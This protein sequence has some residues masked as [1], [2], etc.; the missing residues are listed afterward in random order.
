MKSQLRLNRLAGHLAATPTSVTAWYRIPPLGWSFR[1]NGQRRSLINGMADAYAQLARRSLHLRVTTRPYPVRAWAQRHHENAPD[2]LPSFPDYLSRQVRHLSKFS[3]AEKE[4]YIG[5]SIPLPY[6]TLRPY[7]GAFMPGVTPALLRQLAPKVRETDQVMAASTFRA[8][9]ARLEELEWLLHRSVSL[10]MPAP[11]TTPTRIDEDWEPEDFAEFTDQ[12]DWTAVPFAPTINVRGSIDG[13]EVE[14]HVR[15]LS[16]GR[17]TGQLVA[18]GDPWMQRSD[19]MPFPVEWSARVSVQEAEVVTGQMRR[20]MQKIRAQIRHYKDEHDEEPPTSLSDAHHDAVRVEG[21]LQ[22]GLSGASMRARGWWRVAVSGA[23]EEE[24]VERGRALAKEMRPQVPLVPVLDQYKTARE[25]IPGEP[26]ANNNYVRRMRVDTLA[27]AAPAATARIGDRVGV[28]LGVTAGTTA[29][30]TM[31]EPWLFSTEPGKTSGCTVIVAGLGG[32]KTTLAG[33]I[34]ENTAQGG[35]P[36]SV[37]DP[38][39]RLG[40]LCRLPDLRD[41]SEVVSVMDSEPGI[42]SPFRVVADPNPE[43]F[44]DD[45]DGRKEYQRAVEYARETRRTLINT[46][47]LSL[48][49]AST[50]GNEN[51]EPAMWNALSRVS[52]SRHGKM[53]DVVQSLRHLGGENET[54]RRHASSIA[55]VLAGVAQT[56]HGRLLFGNPGVDDVRDFNEVLLRVYSLKG[57]SLPTDVQTGQELDPD[58]R[59]SFVIYYLAAW[60]TQRQMYFGDPNQRKGIFIDEGWVLEMFAQGRRFIESCDRDSRKHN[61][62]VL[63]AD[64]NPG[65]PLRL[66]MDKYASAVFIGRLD[67]EAAQ[68]EAIKLISKLPEDQGY[69]EVLGELGAEDDDDARKWDDEAANELS[70]EGDDSTP[71]QFVM[72]VGGNDVERI[73]VDLTAHPQLAAALKTSADRTKVRR[74]VSSNLPVL[75]ESKTHSSPAVAVDVEV[76]PAI[77]FLEDQGQGDD[78]GDDQD[79]DQD[80]DLTA[81]QDTAAPT[82]R[83]TPTRPRPTRSTTKTSSAA[84]S[85]TPAAPARKKPTRATTKAETSGTAS[86]RT[87]RKAA[88]ASRRSAQSATTEAAAAS[89]SDADADAESASSAPDES[90]LEATATGTAAATETSGQD[91]QSTTAE[92][93][94]GMPRRRV[95]AA[96]SA[97][98]TVTSAVPTSTHQDSD[99]TMNPPGDPA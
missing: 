9:P 24:A 83:K 29:R 70:G 26:L 74:R 91:P 27:A 98:H 75:D 58:E 66:G 44:H 99:H 76:H 15:I 96:R 14:R 42:L 85:P 92:V 37:L 79:D 28:P 18:P 81:T 52:L 21:E 57:L 39:G 36:W 34:I 20:A 6:E 30:W 62:R 11:L 82:R 1:P 48:L 77:P 19:W 78:Q 84:A 65:G 69:E 68:G 97:R 95:A 41:H 43:H 7:V 93:A 67:S 12:V 72:W 88:T 94:A 73:S 63:F 90:T 71:R 8:R 80:D 32:G 50:R 87:P 31:W 55:D 13:H 86:T 53:E 17:M 4:V 60:L 40:S 47:A 89:G 25:F 61:T 2:P 10:G 3:L 45:E 35:V 46:V 54:L 5:V 22:G 16:V 56:S 64:Q 51:T 49:P 23:T 38:S 33:L 59:L